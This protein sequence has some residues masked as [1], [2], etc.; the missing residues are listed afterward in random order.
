[1]SDCSEAN[2]SSKDRFENKDLHDKCSILV[3]NKGQTERCSCIC[4]LNTLPPY[5]MVAELEGKDADT[6]LEY[7]E[8]DLTQREIKSLEESHTLY[9]RYH[10]QN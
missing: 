5:S 6:F 2:K 8:R 7:N 4:Q 3:D 9:K 10:K 1:M